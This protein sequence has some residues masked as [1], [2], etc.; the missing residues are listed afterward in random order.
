MRF[1]AWA[2]ILIGALLV[3]VA[4]RLGRDSRDLLIGEAMDPAV[5]R[6]IRGFLDDRPEIDTVTELLTMRLGPDSAIVAARVD[7]VPG[8]DSERVE[9][10]LVRVKREMRRRW[11]VADRIFLDIIDASPQDRA[12]ARRE[13]Q[14]L[15]RAVREGEE[16]S[17]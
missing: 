9:E 16:E 13:R 11:P 5:R 1:E 7:L 2:S 17:G 3:Y 14:A 10:A 8:L 15:A 6:S 12:R 4:Y